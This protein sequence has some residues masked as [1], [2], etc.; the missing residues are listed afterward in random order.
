MVTN[1]VE[2]WVEAYTHAWGNNSPQAIERLFSEDARY[3]TAPHR[4]PWAGTQAIVAGW[5]DRADDPGSWEFRYEVLAVAGERAFVRG[6]TAYS[7]GSRFS[8][9]WVLRLAADGR[10]SE[11]TEWWMKE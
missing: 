5:L 9:L 7:D 1:S 2:E 6:W 10:C 3:L 11:F 8:N 4:D